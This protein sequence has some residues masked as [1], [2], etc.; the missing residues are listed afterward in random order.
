MYLERKSD[1]IKFW[2]KRTVYNIRRYE[3][4]RRKFVLFVWLIFILNRWFTHTTVGARPPS[5]SRELVRRDAGVKKRDLPSTNG[6]AWI[7]SRTA[8]VHPNHRQKA[9]TWSVNPYRGV[10]ARP[11]VDGEIGLLI[12]KDLRTREFLR[13]SIPCTLSRA[14]VRRH[15][16]RDASDTAAR[17][18]GGTAAASFKRGRENHRPSVTRKTL[19]AIWI[20]NNRRFG[21]VR[22][23]RR[24]RPWCR[25]HGNKKLVTRLEHGIPFILRR[26]RRDVRQRFGVLNTRYSLFWLLK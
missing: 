26:Y 9:Y 7:D 20:R 19:I 24:A 5:S 8:T 16:P 23:R 4:T 10:F 6:T 12:F 21:R 22:R 13:T 25:R 17:A 14:R 18:H 15:F 2:T 1:V 3:T 11:T